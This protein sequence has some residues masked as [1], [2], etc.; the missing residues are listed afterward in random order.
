MG[1]I[2]SDLEPK[3]LFDQASHGMLFHW[4]QHVKQEPKL[5][6]RNRWFLFPPFD[7]QV[8]QEAVDQRAGKDMMMPCG[9]FPHL[10]EVHAQLGFGSLAA[11]LSRPTQIP[12]PNKSFES[13]AAGS[14][15]DE[16]A[17]LRI[18]ADRA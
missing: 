4:Q 14:V 17:V 8:A 11:L 12:E 15:A 1:A 6:Q 16:I 10:L 9:E 3:D 13:G 18:V 5:R 7:S 2:I